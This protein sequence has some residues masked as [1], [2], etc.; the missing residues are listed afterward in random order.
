MEHTP[1]N[2][3][4]NLNFAIGQTV[5]VSDK[6]GFVM[7]YYIDDAGNY[8]VLVQ[9]NADDSDWVI[10]REEAVNTIPDLTEMYRNARLFVRE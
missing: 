9:F 3:E 10:V 6:P 8:G 5:Q 1:D 4:H 7:G 2:T